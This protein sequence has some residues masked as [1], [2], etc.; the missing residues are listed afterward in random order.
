VRGLQ[1]NP[2]QESDAVDARPFLN[3]GRELQTRVVKFSRT[4]S[5]YSGRILV[6][7]KTATCWTKLALP[8]ESSR[9]ICSRRRTRCTVTTAT[10]DGTRHP[11]LQ[12][13]LSDAGTDQWVLSWRTDADRGSSGDRSVEHWGHM[14]A[15][16]LPVDVR[17]HPA[18]QE[19]PRPGTSTH[20]FGHCCQCSSVTQAT[21]RSTFASFANTAAD[22]SRHGALDRP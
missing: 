12:P 21:G 11:Q 8:L 14:H 19:A 22:R 10:D 18:H 1:F 2:D 13:A 6:R 4:E 7:S 5:D 15:A 20:A 17:V 16:M 3:Y 9:D